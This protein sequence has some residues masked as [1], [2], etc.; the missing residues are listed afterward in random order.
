M[1]RIRE[2]RESDAADVERL[3]DQGFGPGRFA[4]TAYRLREGVFSDSRLSF[5]A[6]DSQTNALLGS[7]RFWPVRI[8]DNLSLLLG[9]LAVEPKL[10]GQ[11]IGIALMQRGIEDAKT[12]R[13]LL[14][15]SRI[16]PAAGGPRAVSGSGGSGPRAGP[17]AEVQRA[18][19]PVGRGC[20]RTHRSTGF[21][22]GRQAG[23]A[24]SF[25]ADQIYPIRHRRP[26]GGDP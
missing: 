7:V 21:R 17:G 16:R 14:R 25:G 24:G 12:L 11:G 9:P 15:E 22:A 8:G 4:K 2:E 1:W 10:R 18:C 3:V 19:H 26:C 5:V 6:Q 13:T 20:S 23:L